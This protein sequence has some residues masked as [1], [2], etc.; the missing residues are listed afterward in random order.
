MSQQDDIAIYGKRRVL[1]AVVGLLSLLYLGRLYQLQLIYSEEYGRKSEENSIRTIPVEPVRGT[2]YDRNGSLVVDN[3]PAFTVSLMPFEFDK[4]NIPYLATLLGVDQDFIRDR[5]KKGEAYSRFAPV[6]IKRDIDF[7]ILAALEEN[8]ERLPGVDTQV[9]SKRFYNTRASAAHILGYT[10]EITETQMKTL[11]DEYA[12]GDVV[13]STGLEAGYESTLRGQKG[14]EF[15]TVNVR[16]QVIGRFD[17]GKNDVPALEGNDLVLSMDFG[18][19]AF[20]ESLMTG[21]RGAVVAIDPRDGGILAMVSKPDYNLSFFSGV[22]PADL[23]RA[24]NADEAAPLFNRATLTRYPPGSTFK[25]LLAIAALET[26]TITPGWRVN[27]GGSFR[28]GNKV[29][30]DLHVHGSVDLVNAIQKSCNVYFYQLMLKTGLDTWSHFGEEFGFG[31][32]S[33]IDIYEENPGLLPSTAFMDRR[34]GKN[35]WTRGFLVSLGIGQGELGV[36][37]LQMALYAATLANGGEY[38]QPHVVQAVMTKNPHAT[39]TL[40]FQTRYLNISAQTWAVVREG[41][42]RVVEET[43]GTGGMARVAGIQSAGKTGTAQN[44][45]GPD[46]A[47]YVGFAPFDHP[48]IAIAVLVENAGFGG[49]TAAPIAGLC[50]ER[51]LYGHLVRPL[52]APTARRTDT[53]H[54]QHAADVR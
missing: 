12:P 35:G 22:T 13:G 9:E 10:K 52:P 6:K 1:F 36:T 3:R 8:R 31:R 41:M 48:R 37:P 4:N 47:W 2:M 34:Y 25:M 49:T 23:W 30:K 50:I 7:R 51:Y 42:R 29:F 24:L 43:G 54:P 45:H 46:H 40:S 17:G 44:P 14:A 33:G 18:L 39:D 16:G 5:L 20:A 26:G 53:H 21:R 27:C 38:H 32:L 11:G 19:Q 28:F 15:S